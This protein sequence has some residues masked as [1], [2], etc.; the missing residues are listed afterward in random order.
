[1]GLV[2]PGLKYDWTLDFGRISSSEQKI[3]VSV[4]DSE[5]ETAVE[6]LSRWVQETNTIF[7]ESAF[8]TCVQVSFISSILCQDQCSLDHSGL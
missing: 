1:M 3:F 2:Y 7:E 4:T 6:M 8:E 5:S